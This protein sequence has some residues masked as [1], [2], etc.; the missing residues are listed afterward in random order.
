M[1]FVKRG[2]DAKK[3]QKLCY[4]YKAWGLALY[5]EDLLPEDEFQAWVH[6]PANPA[7]YQKYKDYGWK[8]IPKGEDNSSEFNEKELELLESVWLT[9]GDMSANALEAQTHLEAPWR[10]AREGYEDYK[11]CSVPIKEEDMASFY[12][13]IYQKNQGE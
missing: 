2:Y 10:N 12:L 9:Y 8:D 4:Y 5:Q 13:M 1:V 11:N 3:L 6:G 7:L